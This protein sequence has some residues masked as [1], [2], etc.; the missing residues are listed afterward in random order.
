MAED[1][2]CWQPFAALAAELVAGDEEAG[3]EELEIDELGI[4]ELGAED[5]ATATLDEVAGVEVGFSLLEPPPPPPQ[6]VSKPINEKPT[7]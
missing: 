6:A 3:A 5:E 4:E 7:S 2:C 1:D